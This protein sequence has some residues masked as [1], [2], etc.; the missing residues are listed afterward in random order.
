MRTRRIAAVPFLEMTPEFLAQVRHQIA[1]PFCRIREP[2]CVIL[3][4]DILSE[5]SPSIAQVTQH[6]TIGAQKLEP[7]NHSFLATR[8]S[9][10]QQGRYCVIEIDSFM[11]KVFWIGLR[12]QAMA[13]EEIET[14]QKID[15][16]PAK[17]GPPLID[18][19]WS[20]IDSSPVIAVKRPH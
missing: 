13:F 15:L 3:L 17:E 16:N 7:L 12:S 20:R 4:C 8:E 10:Y 6:E 2:T 14:S 11:Q 19:L 9:A 1:D 5:L 18:Q